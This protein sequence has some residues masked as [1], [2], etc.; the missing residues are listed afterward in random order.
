MVARKAHVSPMNVQIKALRGAAASFYQLS[1]QQSCDAT[2]HFFL[3]FGADNSLWR[4][5]IAG[6][7]LVFVRFPSAL[8]RDV[9]FPA[10]GHNKG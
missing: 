3:S 2:S 6:L 5:H 9:H 4:V 1:T 8:L 10:W 7:R